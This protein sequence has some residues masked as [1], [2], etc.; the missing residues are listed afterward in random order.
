MSF[1][2]TIMKKYIIIII[3]EKYMKLLLLLLVVVIGIMPLEL[4]TMK[5]ILMTILFALWIIYVFIFIYHNQKKK[6]HDNKY[7]SHLY[8]KD[9]PRIRSA[10]ELT[11]LMNGRINH[12]LLG[13]LVMELIRKRALL[14]RY[15]Q[16]NDDY[17]FVGNNDLETSEKVTYAEKYLLE[18]LLI[19]IGNGEKVSL[20]LIKKD[21]YTN[22]AYFLSCYDEWQTFASFEGTKPTFFES[23]KKVLD[24]ILGYIVLSIILAL[25][26]LYNS[27]LPVITVL[28]LGSTLVLIIYINSYFIRTKEGNSEYLRWKSFSNSIKKG[29]ACNNISNF[30]LIERVVVYAKILKVN[31]RMMITNIST[32]TERKIDDNEFIKYEMTG[33]TDEICKKM[34]RFVSTALVISFF[35]PINKGSRATVKRNNKRKG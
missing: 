34:K 6:R 3:E 30:S 5:M 8:I 2:Y 16:E 35:L 22:S 27:L 9:V 32:Q 12:D 10:A 29:D 25:I 15:N 24:S 14:L 4:T 31:T 20:S 23:T 18:W 21:A 13:I 33:I 11:Y 28:S 1:C 7:Q 26:S 17:V 19:K